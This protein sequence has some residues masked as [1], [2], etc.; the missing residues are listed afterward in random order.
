MPRPGRAALLLVALWGCGPSAQV[1]VQVMAL[2][3]DVTGLFTTTQVQLVTVTDMVALKGS[4]INLVGGV[5]VRLDASDPLQA[6][7]ASETDDQRYAA[8]VKNT[9]MD[10]SA[11]YIDRSGVLWPADFHTWNM[12]TSYYNFE[13]AYA[14]FVGVYDGADPAELRNQRV[15]YWPDVY[16]NSSSP[17]VDNALY[18]ALIKSFVLVPP[19][20]FQQ[21]PLAMN[22]GVIGHEFSHRA[23]N[24]KALSDSG[25]NPAFSA[26]SGSAFNLLKSIDEGF[27]DFHGYGVTCLEVA[28]C[29]PNFLDGSIPDPTLV[30]ARDLSRADACLDANLRNA[31]LNFQPSQWTSDADMYSL[32][33]LW[34]ASLYQAANQ[35]SQ[36]EAMQKALVAAYDDPSPTT[37]GLRQLVNGNLDT[38]Q[39]FTAEAVADVLL[40]HLG[41]GTELQRLTCSQLLTRLQLSCTL[42]SGTLCA[43]IPNCPATAA[44][45][46]SI[47]PTL[48]AP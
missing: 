9:G 26:W 44:R 48:A 1:P 13:R 8:V 14:Y 6:N 37:P 40:A 27:A 34:A 7:L 12:V 30:H 24:Y 18:L 39:N 17:L 3:P 41:A 35:A 28:G 32:G 2:A 16:W 11:T 20:T 23:F 10:V 21:I 31:Y 42:G 43:E 38:P 47:C 46:A 29:R 5:Q 33:T 36:L 19:Q 15:M 4:V 45:D 25:D 22:I